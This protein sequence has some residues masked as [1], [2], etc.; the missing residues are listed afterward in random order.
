MS[1]STTNLLFQQGQGREQPF[2]G[3]LKCS[4]VGG[5]QIVCNPHALDTFATCGRLGVEEQI[6]RARSAVGVANPRH[7]DARFSIDIDLSWRANP[8]SPPFA[9]ASVPVP[10]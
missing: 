6:S 10:A 9:L 3:S 5:V 7:A 4:P 8:G 2:R 1:S